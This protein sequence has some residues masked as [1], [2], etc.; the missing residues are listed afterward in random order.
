M[1]VTHTFTKLDETP[2]QTFSPTNPTPPNHNRLSDRSDIDTNRLLAMFGCCHEEAAATSAEINNARI[3]FL[4]LC[5]DSRMRVKEMSPAFYRCNCLGRKSSRHFRWRVRRDG[6]VIFYQRREI[7]RCCAFED[8]LSLSPVF[9]Y[10]DVRIWK[11][12]EVRNPKNNWV[13]LLT[14]TPCV[15]IRR[16]SKRRLAARTAIFSVLHQ[17]APETLLFVA[18]IPGGL[19]RYAF[20][21]WRHGGPD[22][23]GQVV[24]QKSERISV[25]VDNKHR[26]AVSSD[27]R[28][29][30]LLFLIW[31]YTLREIARGLPHKWYG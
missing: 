21:G 19:V 10:I 29:P 15:S 17:H 22:N 27:D 25:G 9:G 4:Q 1:I 13:V 16:R 31:W 28:V 26:D 12:A 18:K 7:R 23:Y 6:P 11:N 8:A 3:W 5:F 14:L 30:V 20:H 2:P 24:F